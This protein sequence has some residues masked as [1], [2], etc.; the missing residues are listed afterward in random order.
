MKKVKAKRKV[1]K[2]GS[3]GQPIDCNAAT[4]NFNAYCKEEQNRAKRRDALNNNLKTATENLKQK[5]QELKTSENKLKKQYPNCKQQCID[6]KIKN[7]TAIQND[8]AAQ[9]KIIKDKNST[10]KE[11]KAA[12]QKIK[13]NNAAIGKIPGG[14]DISNS[15][16]P[17][18]NAIKNLENQIDKITTSL[19][20]II[21]RLSELN[22]LKSD[23][24]NTMKDANP[25]CTVPSC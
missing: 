17:L 9:Q 7:V 15:I 25:P 10:P 11:K 21:D 22:Q 20:P 12:Q 8:T 16:V 19:Q 18:Q 1:Y 24:E 5:N 13:N 3:T 23:L 4:K 14:Q 2:L 6:N